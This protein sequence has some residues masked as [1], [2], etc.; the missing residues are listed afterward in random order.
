MPGS[1][2]ISESNVT[3]TEIFF[4]TR[5]IL[6]LD[7]GLGA[8][9]VEIGVLGVQLQRLRVEIQGELKVVLEEGFLRPLLQIR[10]HEKEE[11]RA[12]KRATSAIRGREEKRVDEQLEGLIRD[13]RGQEL[14]TRG[15]GVD[16]G[17]STRLRST[18]SEKSGIHS[19][20]SDVISPTNQEG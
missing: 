1:G 12:S 18:A 16:R 3:I 5:E 19:P 10:R 7:V 20:T 6:E 2:N 17:V 15:D 4:I 11:L 8:V 9:G 14:K 13:R